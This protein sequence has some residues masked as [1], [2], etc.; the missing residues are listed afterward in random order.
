MS[1]RMD[2]DPHVIAYYKP[3]GQAYFFTY[4]DHQKTQV[5]RVLGRFASDPELDLTWYD[6]AVLSKH[7]REEGTC[8]P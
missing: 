3:S 5:M 6:A 2:H 4:H 7:I 8:T 1:N